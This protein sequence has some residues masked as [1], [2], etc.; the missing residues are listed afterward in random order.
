M[1]ART[2]S[3]GDFRVRRNPAMVQ[4]QPGAGSIARIRKAMAVGR[5]GV[6]YCDPH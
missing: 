6:I 2:V 5:V 3:H 1:T 4:S